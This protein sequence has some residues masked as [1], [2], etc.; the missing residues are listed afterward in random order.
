MLGKHENTSLNRLDV[1][2]Q[3][4]QALRAAA[5]SGNHVWQNPYGLS[6][7]QGMVVVIP[8]A[9]PGKALAL[10]T[11]IFATSGMALCQPRSRTPVS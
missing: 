9:F 7:E 2:G 10:D 3:S 4:G 5:I 1:A 6:S 11:G 8:A